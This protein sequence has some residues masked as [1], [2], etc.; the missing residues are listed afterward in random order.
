MPICRAMLRLRFRLDSTRRKTDG[1]NYANGHGRH[2]T[3]GD[4]LRELANH[5]CGNP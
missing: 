2:G 3:R 5:S 4:L 1:H